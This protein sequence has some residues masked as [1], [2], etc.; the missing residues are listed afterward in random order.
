MITKFIKHAQKS[1]FETQ[2]EPFT[3]D[4]VNDVKSFL[5]FSQIP[6][7]LHHS[8]SQLKN[9]IRIFHFDFHP[10]QAMNATNPNFNLSSLMVKHK[11]THTIQAT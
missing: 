4:C 7:A 3:L 1:K 8:G 6:T 2:E 9:L 5:S 10:T 11:T